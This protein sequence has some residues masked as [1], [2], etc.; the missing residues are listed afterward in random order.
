MS[1]DNEKKRSNRT[2]EAFSGLRR[3]FGSI[4]WGIRFVWNAN[5][6]MFV[7][8]VVVTS[9]RSLLPVVTVYLNSAI[10]AGLVQSGL[11]IRAKLLHIVWLAASLGLAFFASEVL[12]LS[13]G[14]IRDLYQL[15][16][17]NFAGEWI[18]DKAAS[19]DLAFYEDAEFH[20]KL[21]LANREAMFR[22]MQL[23]QQIVALIS[24]CVTIVSFGVV[25]MTW[26][27]TLIVVMVGIMGLT[28]LGAGRAAKRD[29]EMKVRNTEG[30]RKVSYVSGVLISDWMAKE[31]RVLSLQSYFLK[32]LKELME[33]LYRQEQHISIRRMRDKSTAALFSVVLR[34][35]ILLYAALDLFGGQIVFKGF[36]L[37]TQSAHSLFSGLERIANILAKLDEASLFATAINDVDKLQSEVEIPSSG[38]KQ[39]AITTPPMIE[40]KDVCFRYPKCDR[41]AI[42]DVNLRISPGETIMILGENG[43]G[44]TTIVKLLAG[45][46]HP[47]A[48]RIEFNGTD[49]RS[50]ERSEIRRCLGVLLQDF[51]VYN[52]DLLSNI[53]I[54]DRFCERTMEEVEKAAEAVGLDELVT[55]LP[56]GYGTVLGR[57]FK[58]GHEL[59]GGQRKLVAIA[60]AVL[61]QAPVLIL[62]EPTAWLDAKRKSKLI[63]SLISRRKQARE[64]TILISHDMSLAKHA[65]RVMLF[66]SGRLV[67]TGTYDELLGIDAFTGTRR[68]S[69]GT[70][71]GGA[72][73]S[74]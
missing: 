57:A 30:E 11:E 2:A 64:T 71:S 21:Q 62:D 24:E 1:K 74:D 45:L 38:R 54:G 73:S 28:Y 33:Y 70:N 22:P 58:R 3:R 12:Q 35:Y 61:R 8:L 66:R 52:M 55:E 49:V 50:L 59:S 44:K 39:K 25:L 48:G 63:M 65:D 18:A 56:D 41:Y 9:L 46:Y 13:A 69:I 47:T 43:A 34:P 27:P 72:L 19:L 17:S 20:D 32:W 67:Q 31:I 16:A 60:R 15:R 37:Y 6:Q 23:V 5:P 42:E 51:N 40:F 7:W 4:S 26:Q 68:E 10:L 53:T 14:V 36:C 29:Y